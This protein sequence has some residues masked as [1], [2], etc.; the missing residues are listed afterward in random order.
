MAGSGDDAAGPRNWQ[1]GRIR[2]LEKELAATTRSTEELAGRL[3]ILEKEL[4]SQQVR[5]LP[6]VR[7]ER[8]G[9][10]ERLSEV[11]AGPLE[12]EVQGNFY[13]IGSDQESE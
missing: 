10:G 5:G 7:A 9:H 3:R 4:A 2:I 8:V 11:H 13:Y 12:V 1:A 6:E